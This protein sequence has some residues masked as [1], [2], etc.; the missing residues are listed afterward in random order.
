M[1]HS[2]RDFFLVNERTL[3]RG[4]VAAFAIGTVVFLIACVVRP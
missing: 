4:A 2:P 3:V 1:Y